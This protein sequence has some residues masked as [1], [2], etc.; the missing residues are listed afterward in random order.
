MNDFYSIIWMHHSLTSTLDHLSSFQFFVIIF[1]HWSLTESLII[2]VSWIPKN[3]L[4]GWK[5]MI[6]FSSL[7]IQTARVP[8]EILYQFISLPT[9]YESTLC[10]I[11]QGCS[12]VTTGSQNSSHSSALDQKSINRTATLRAGRRK[13]YKFDNCFVKASFLDSWDSYPELVD[14]KSTIIMKNSTVPSI[15]CPSLRENSIL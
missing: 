3:R 7:L 12:D 15:L 4:T 9:V 1:G 2:S 13:W 11:T 5:G 14:T 6:F 8:P 10:T